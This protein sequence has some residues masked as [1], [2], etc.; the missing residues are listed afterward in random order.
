[1]TIRY[2]QRTLEPLLRQAAGEF[3]AVVLTEIMKTLLHHGENPQVYFWRTSSGAEV[4][5]VVDAGG[6]LIPIEVTLS[7]TPR[8]GMADHIATFRTAVGDKAAPGY[9]VH[10]GEVRLPLAPG[11]TAL[12]FSDL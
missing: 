9:V 7:A 11:V 8:P 5:I 3:P 10:P 2:I 6:T 12:P 4:D 1:V